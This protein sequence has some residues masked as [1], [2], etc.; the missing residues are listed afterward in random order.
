MECQ[1]SCVQKPKHTAKPHKKCIK[2]ETPHKQ[3]QEGS[4]ALNKSTDTIQELV[5]AHSDPLFGLGGDALPYAQ[6]AIPS[7]E[8]ED[9]IEIN[10]NRHIVKQKNAELCYKARHKKP[11]EVI[12]K[13]CTRERPLERSSCETI[14]EMDDEELGHNHHT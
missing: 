13:P 6:G 10:I 14:L 9:N 2:K 5:S 1:E 7:Q 8:S 4:D 3:I 11:L 12:T